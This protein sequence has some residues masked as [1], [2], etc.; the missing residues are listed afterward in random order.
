MKAAMPKQVASGVYSSGWD[1][2][3]AFFVE[4]DEGGLWLVD[5]GIQAGAE[6]IGGGLGRWAA[7]RASSAASSSRTCTA[8]TSAGSPPSRSTPERRSGCR[9]RTP[10][11]CVRA[12]AAGRSSR[13]PVWCGR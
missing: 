13:V 5:T 12:C 4:D 6:R 1:G 9:P 2:V 10:R 11:P 7:R 8:T 3:N